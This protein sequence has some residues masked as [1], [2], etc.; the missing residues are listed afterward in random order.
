MK[1]INKE[2]LAEIYKERDPQSRKYDFGL[3]VVI[4]GSEFYSGSPALS[5]MAAFRTGADM[6]R[7][8][9]PQRAADIIASF[10]PNMA[11]YP[12]EGKRVGKNHLSTLISMT[13][14]AKSVSRG[15]VAVV[16]GG[17]I[18]RS[19]ETQET[20]LEYLSKLTVPVVIDADAIYAI[21][22]NLEVLK[23]KECLVTPH[24]FEF[25]SLTGREVYELPLEEKI[26]AVRKEAER[27]GI[28]ILLKG[29]TDIIS[30][31]KDVLINK[32]GSPYLTVGGSGDT[33][34]GV[35]GALVSRKIPLLKAGGAAAFI[36]AS[37][38]SLAAK[39]LKDSMTA[40]DLIDNINE[41]IK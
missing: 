19:E 33:L 15:N 10:N 41:I 5:A 2:I 40:T 28:T 25:F 17:G 12:L 34:A 32:I 16:L 30:D 31:G 22:D 27:M 20:I 26:K 29:E 8:I 35:A 14:S 23:D 39:T 4:G 11:A 38:G 36:N 6:V 24:Y 7:I 21:K 13:E 37:A 1:E 18:G 9:A 3:V